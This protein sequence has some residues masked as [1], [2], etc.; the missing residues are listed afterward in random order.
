MTTRTRTASRLLHVRD[1]LAAAWLAACLLLSPAVLAEEALLTSVEPRIVDFDE[2]LERRVLRALVV[3][4]P[5][6]YFVDGAD[7]HGI[8]YDALELFREF[9]DKKFDTGARKF[10][11]A[12][13]PVARDQLIPLLRE[14]MGDV[15]VANL[16][17]TPERLELVDFTD[18][19]LTGVREIL[20]TGPSA[21]EIKTLND[22]S[23][24]RIHVRPSS[25]YHDS[26][27]KLNQQFKESGLEPVELVDADEYLEDNDLLEMVNAGLL[28]MVVVDSHKAEFWKEIFDQ[29]NVRDDIAVSGEGDI[30]WALRK[31]S[32]KL[33]KVLNEFVAENKKGTMIGNILYKRYLKENK[34]VR[35]AM[36]PAE[37]KRFNETVE[38]FRQYA[39]EYDFDWLMLAALG[40]QE[41]RLDQSTRS[42]AGAIG[43]MQ[44][45]PTTAADKNVGIPDI[46]NLES[47]I[48]AGTKYLRFVRDRY[49]DDPAISDVDQTLF[50]FASYNA[51][52]A[53]IGK[54]RNEAAESGLDPNTWFGNVEHIVAKRVGRETVQY[55]SNIYKYYVAYKL[56]TESHDD[57]EVAKEKL[58]ESLQ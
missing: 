35:N 28:P 34:W 57:R 19:T 40:Y 39:D 44:L 18:P 1:R 45:L 46:E 48:H 50:S 5:S 54:L 26:L 15:A 33:M 17:I 30:G 6:L 13:I 32:P 22:L 27:L 52:P 37:V 10:T 24:K 21:P 58:E 56:L 12:F 3:R 8:A 51:G 20:V 47:N 25:S 41:S 4:N 16:T 23:G 42:P 53:K 31:D 49:F 36:D 2:I 43:V 38:H 7:Q 29:L 11:V 55:V 14:G 9:V